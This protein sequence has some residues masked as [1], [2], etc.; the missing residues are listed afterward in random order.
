MLYLVLPSLLFYYLNVSYSRSIT[1]EGEEIAGFS[2]ID[3]VI[4]FERDSVSSG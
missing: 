4:K 1:S 3:S 2:A